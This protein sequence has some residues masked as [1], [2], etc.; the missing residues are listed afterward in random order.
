M[1]K[2]PPVAGA[3]PAGSQSWSS[4]EPLRRIRRW[5][6]PG[7]LMRMIRSPQRSK[8]KRRSPIALAQGTGRT[9]VRMEASSSGLQ[10]IAGA[11][12]AGVSGSGAKGQAPVGPPPCQRMLRNMDESAGRSTDRD[13]GAGARPASRRVCRLPHR[14]KLQIATE[15]FPSKTARIQSAHRLI[16]RR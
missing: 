10:A 12:L 11:S 1:P 9:T 14:A 2:L 6:P 16:C 5:V 7:A 13:L 3:S 8:W 4:G 15:P